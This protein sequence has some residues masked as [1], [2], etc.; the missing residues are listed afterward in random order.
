MTGII[1]IGIGLALLVIMPEDPR[2]TRM[3]NESESALAIAR[4]NADA[5]VKVDGRKEKTTWKL[6]LHSFN[7]WVR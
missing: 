2:T 5:V 1:T 6:I 7:I 3:L 4:L